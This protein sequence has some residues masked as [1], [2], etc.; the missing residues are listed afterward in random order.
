MAKTI[1][2]GDT[3]EDLSYF[4][5][6][7][8]PN[9]KMWNSALFSEF[10]NKN[11]T[12]Y[13]SLGDVGISVFLKILLE[14]QHIIYQ[15][16]T[17]DWSDNGLKQT[18]ENIL[19]LFG[20]YSPSHK[21][22][23]FNFAQF[24]LDEF[25]IQKEHLDADIAS[26]LWIQKKICLHSENN[27]LGLISHRRS[28]CPQIWV[29]GC[30]YA[31]GNGLNNHVSQRYGSLIAKN[32]GQHT[33]NIACGGSSIDFAADQI[34]RS[35]IRKGDLIIWG[36]T[37][38]QRYTWFNE[39]RIEK[40]NAPYIDQN[41]ISVSRKKFLQQNLLD[42]SR[43]YLS[44]R[45]IDQ[46]Y[47]LCEKLGCNLI[48]IYHDELS[49]KKHVDTMKSF[50]QNYPGFLDINEIMIKRFGGENKLNARYHLDSGNDGKHPGPKTHQIWAEILL[51][52][53]KKNNYSG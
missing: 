5:K 25:W 46:V 3:T 13:I 45:Y 48:L 28:I 35:D 44:Q 50:L 12:N 22:S 1:I 8:D 10:S 40:I 7:Q 24:T 33:T 47:N 39:D 18:T 15:N 42:E 6:N 23:N 38:T 11:H 49:L 43:I 53:I 9:A 17:G 2:I 32:L 26:N 4:A 51:E 20:L 37:A 29:A 21:I 27:F 31:A 41:D 16:K 14:Y 19:Y 36:L 34:L 52:F 30:S